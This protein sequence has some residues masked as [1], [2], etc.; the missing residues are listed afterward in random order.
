[1]ANKK[2]KRWR[3]R[4]AG[5]KGN[6]YASYPRPTDS[7]VYKVRRQEPQKKPPSELEQRYR[8]EKQ[9]A[10]IS[11]QKPKKNRKYKSAPASKQRAQSYASYDEKEQ[12]RIQKAKQ[13]GRNNVLVRAA[14][15]A[16]FVVL[17]VVLSIFVFFKIGEIQVV[18]SEQ[19][20]AAQVIEASGIELGDNLFAPTAKG[21]QRKFDTALPYIRAVT[22]KHQ[23]PDTLIISVE[24]TSAQFAFENTDEEGTAYYIL[25]D[26]DLK[27]LERADKPPAGAAIVE[28]AAIMPAEMGEKAEFE[29]EEKGELVKQIKRVFSENGLEN[30]TLIDMTSIV[31]ISVVY[32]DAITVQIG[33]TNELDYKCK[34]AAKSIDDALAD[35]KNAKGTVNVK[36]ADE[37][38]QA[39]F[40]PG[41]KDT[42]QAADTKKS[43]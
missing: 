20:T 10:G 17:A 31:D 1:M 7:E 42:A 11:E 37:T 9:T 5:K 27:L 4:P 24:E 6:S 33:Q 2:V 38:K 22:I 13:R 36:Q 32:A 15:A 35:N 14:V 29:Q 12:Q 40:N 28:G 16:A 18:G 19:Y 3:S 21:V 34:L 26:A 8:E 30:V 43:D 41:T 23:L 39:Y 25:T